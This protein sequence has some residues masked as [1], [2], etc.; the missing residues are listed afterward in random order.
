MISIDCIIECIAV[1]EGYFEI[2]A[3][4]DGKKKRQLSLWLAIS[5]D[6]CDSGV[7]LTD[8]NI[9]IKMVYFA[10]GCPVTH[11]LLSAGAMDK[12]L[13]SKWGSAVLLVVTQRTVQLWGSNQ[14]RIKLGEIVFDEEDVKRYGMHVC[15]AWCSESRSIV[16]MV[17]LLLPSLVVASSGDL[18]SGGAYDMML[19]R[20][21]IRLF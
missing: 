12:V 14:H 5:L 13:L 21:C 2:T 15:G 16:A 3:K 19:L 1:G 6:C 17:S 4:L 10:Y 9:Y 8:R 20:V 18:C 11:R 7:W